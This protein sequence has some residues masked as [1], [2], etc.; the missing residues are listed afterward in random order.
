MIILS[1]STRDIVVITLG[2]SVKIMYVCKVFLTNSE[3]DFGSCFIK[4]YIEIKTKSE[5]RTK[6]FVN[7]PVKDLKRSI[8]FYKEIGFSQNMRFS[9]EYA[10]CMAL[11]E[12]IYVMLLLE[13][14]FKDYTNKN[15]AD[16]AKTTEVINCLSA[17]N[18]TSVDEMADKA[19]NAGGAV[20]K[21]PIDLELMYGR[22]FCD[23][24]GHIWEIMWVDESNIVNKS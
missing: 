1:Q 15:V 4:K 24:D 10:A 22:S 13:N 18:R 5:M 21:E 14:Y 6:I 23:P 19:M 17:P 3:I 16:G 20:S 9:G 12:E 2:E 7:F 11:T 8:E